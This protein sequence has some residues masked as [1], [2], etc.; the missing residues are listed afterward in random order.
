M[1]PVSDTLVSSLK[2]RAAKVPL[3]AALWRWWRPRAALPSGREVIA[4]YLRGLPRGGD[5]KIVFGGHW[6]DNP[7]WLLLTEHHQDITKRLD[8]GDSVADVIFSEHVI[9]H[10][11]FVGGVHFLREAFRIL[12][13]GGVCRSFARC[14]IGCGVQILLTRMG[15]STLRNPLLP[16]FGIEDALLRETLNLRGI[17]EDPEAFLF[18]NIYMGHGHRFI[19]T[20]GLMMKV[21]KAIGFSGAQRFAPGEGSRPADCIERRRRAF[22]SALTGEMNSQRLRSRSTSKVSLLKLSNRTRNVS[23]EQQC[24]RPISGV[25]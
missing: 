1:S 13:P 9:E 7:G 18:A 25:L 6:S 17:N 22:T 15:R 16:A 8:F 24:C 19:W 2:R 4:K 23:R 11:P 5:L 3:V 20:S 14:S 10:V 21:M 12:K